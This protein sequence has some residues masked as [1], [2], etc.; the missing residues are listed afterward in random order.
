MWRVEYTNEKGHRV[1]HG[2]EFFSRKA[3]RLWCKRAQKTKMVLHG[4]NG[5]LEPFT[6]G[7]A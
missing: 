1:F 6:C 4:P 2:Q 3:A 5:E 7:V